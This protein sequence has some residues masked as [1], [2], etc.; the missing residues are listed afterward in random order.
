MNTDESGGMIT[1][2]GGL[3]EWMGSPKPTVIE[4]ATPESVLLDIPSDGD[5]PPLNQD[6]VTRNEALNLGSP[7]RVQH[8]FACCY[9]GLM[10]RGVLTSEIMTASTSDPIDRDIEGILKIP[11]A[12]YERR[13]F[14]QETLAWL[15]RSIGYRLG[16]FLGLEPTN[17]QAPSGRGLVVVGADAGYSEKLLGHF[18]CYSDELEPVKGHAHQNGGIAVDTDVLGETVYQTR[19]YQELA[20]PAG[21]GHSLLCF[22][23][24]RDRPYGVLMLGRESHIPFSIRDQMRIRALAPVMALALS[25]Y[26]PRRRVSFGERKKSNGFGLSPRELEIS[27]YLVLGYSNREIAIALDTSPHTVRNQLAS[28]FRKAEVSNRAELVGRLLSQ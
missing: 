6:A 18:S 9:L 22:L 17:G 15:G 24:L 11:L 20:R 16:F 26:E 3:A 14:Q 4:E 21:G 10:N 19:Y 5:V 12:V 7:H 27:N 13:T 8:C 2:P 1:T 25:S 28:L 23:T